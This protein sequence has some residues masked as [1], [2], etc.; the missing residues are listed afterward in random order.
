MAQLYKFAIIRIADGARGEAL[1]VGLAI[2]NGDRLDVRVAKR[3][4]KLRALSAAIDAQHVREALGALPELDAQLASAGHSSPTERAKM[5]ANL[6]PLK[7]SELG[8]FVAEDVGAYET[9]VA[10][11]LRHLVDPEPALP[12]VKRRSS[13]LLTQLK[14]AFRQEKVLAQKDEN[15]DSHRIVPAFELDEGLVADLVLKNGATHVVETVDVSTE[16]VSTRRAISE[17]AVA[18]LV[19]ERARMKFGEDETRS[20]LVYNASSN[21]ERAAQPSLDAAAHQGAELVNWASTDERARFIHSLASIAE[22]R[23]RA[24]P[25]VRFDIPGGRGGFL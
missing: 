23:R 14:H 12:R 5:L 2:F 20:R 8:T 13:R 16:E 15:L 6:G 24:R 17:I 10:S 1:N 11:T 7:L 4:D 18:A 9:R 22:P 19:L 3:L 21:I 25:R